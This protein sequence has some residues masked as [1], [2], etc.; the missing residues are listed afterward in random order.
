MVCGNVT[1]F[2]RASRQ[3]IGA[4]F[5]C[6]HLTIRLY[7]TWT[8]TLFLRNVLRYTSSLVTFFP[9]SWKKKC[10][11]PGSIQG[12]HGNGD[13]G[14]KILFNFRGNT[15]PWGGQRW[16][17]PL[18]EH[19]V[20][21]GYGYLIAWTRPQSNSKLATRGRR[22]IVNF[23]STMKCVAKKSSASSLVRCTLCW[24]FTPWCTAKQQKT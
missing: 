18:H 16:S 15:H 23:S 7:P 3:R 17:A 19:T 14:T 11:S 1:F 13:H 22:S 4:G 9:F 10:L 21:S 6:S 24:T 5:S 8:I 20:G 12:S 2:L